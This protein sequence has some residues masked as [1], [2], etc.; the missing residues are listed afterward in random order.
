VNK[1]AANKRMLASKM[2]NISFCLKYFIF[3]I[4]FLWNKKRLK[5]STRAAIIMN[6]IINSIAGLSIERI[7]F[8]KK[9]D[10]DNENV[11]KR[12]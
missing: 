1:Y 11:A 9:I 8:L 2:A 10:K 4:Y 7:C 12:L 3:T 6:W 5:L